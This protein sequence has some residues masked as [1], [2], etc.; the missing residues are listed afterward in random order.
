VQRIG[1][2]IGGTFT[3]LLLIDADGRATIAKTLTTPD[4]P[5]RAVEHELR[6][7]LASTQASE[8][9]TAPK[10]PD[11]VLVHGT[12]LVTNAIIER[13]GPRTALLATAGFRD[14]VEIGRE[15]R[16][17]LYDLN[18][19]VPRPLVPRH[20]RFDV[21][22]RIA[23]DGSVLQPL[24]EEFVRRLGGELRDNDVRAVAVCYLHSFRNPAHERRT[25]DLIA[26]VAPGVR[27]SIS[28]EV[29]PEIRE[30]Q[31]A[32][33]TAANVYVQE[34]VAAYLRHMEGRLR[35]LGFNGAFFAMLSAGGIGTIETASRF[36]VRLLESGPAAGALAAASLGGK[37]GF[38]DLLSFDMGGT[39]AKLCAILDGRPLKVH[40]FE[41]DRV[42]RFRKGSGLP[43]TIPVIDM[44]EIGAG[45]GSIAR[46]S[47]VGLLTV[48][49]E[50][51]GADP[52]PACYGFGGRSPTVTDADLVLGYLNPKY[53]LGGRMRLD[54]DAAHDSLGRLAAGLGLTV[55]QT[56][57]G[58][59]QIVNENMANAARAHLSERGAHPGNMPLFAFGGAGP[60]HAYH[61]AEI[62]RLPAIISPLGAGVG[63][64]FGLL[65]AP[66][67]FDFVRSARGQLDDLDWS[68]ANRL[69]ADMDREGRALLEGSG[70]AR[71][72]TVYT[73]TADMRYLGQGHEISVPLPAG[74]LQSGDAETIRAAFGR[75]YESRYGRPGPAVPLE[76]INWRVTVSGPN[77]TIDTRVAMPPTPGGALKGSRRAFCLERRGYVDTPVYDRYALAP[78]DVVDGPAIVEEQESTLVIGERGRA[79]VD[80]HLTMIVEFQR[81]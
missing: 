33:T 59:H 27:V 18:L 69:L 61:L 71:E 42:Y 3:D 54:V 58:I 24:D 9:D 40:E 36:P 5:S 22:E 1:V 70:V 16:Y 52:G 47:A 49:P 38:N 39:T 13:K 66:L 28:S 4:D 44:I 37:T 19:E 20:L 63:S 30:F 2:D 57:W 68:A 67:A 60:V 21:P 14:A 64:T 62:L 48:G 77:P 80:Q 56:A 8:R 10:T 17:E 53:F 29:A 25:A 72:A 6:G 45:G 81:G 55:E 75:V 65:A 43:I 79:R 74:V 12:T 73:R 26:E 41:V 11:A 7:L 23:A 51:A 35:N 46:Q 31:R 34:R 32:S 15:H 76:V 78:G 50:S